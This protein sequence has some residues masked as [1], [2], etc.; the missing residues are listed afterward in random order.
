MSISNNLQLYEFIRTLS[1]DLR[2]S[3]K[4]QAASALEDAL[5]ISTV[6]GEIL[7]EIRLQLRKLRSSTPKVEQSARQTVDDA[8]NYLDSVLGRQ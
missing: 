1:Q 3:G 5:S 8:L 7:G 6:P 2:A 4:E